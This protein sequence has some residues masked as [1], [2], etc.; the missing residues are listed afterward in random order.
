MPPIIECIVRTSPLTDYAYPYIAVMVLTWNGGQITL[1]CLESVERLNYPRYTVVVVDNGSVD[2]SVERIR[3]DFPAAE[4]IPLSQNMGLCEG[5][6]TGLRWSLEHGCDYILLLNND[7]ALAP[8]ALRR[9]VDE[10]ERHPDAGLISPKIYL[11]NP[12]DDRFYWTGGWLTLNPF[13]APTRGYR[14]RDRGQY[15]ETIEVQLSA[16][17]AVLVRCQMVRDVGLLDLDY[18]YMC[19]DFDWSLR[20]NRHG[21]KVLYVPTAHV[22]HRESST[23]GFLSPSMAY[24]YLRNMLLLARR[25]CACPHLMQAM[26]TFQVFLFMVMFLV[27]GRLRGV[28]APLWALI[29]YHRGRLGRV[30]HGL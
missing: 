1:D 20:A 6:N 4:V 13:R 8:D 2:D 21:Y 5:Y 14:R 17:T 29:D 9:L 23:V 22:W 26:L 12:P 11:G 24:Y 10:A 3:T 27:T 25:Y 15:D 18:F 28:R 16:N 30:K 19:E 7:V